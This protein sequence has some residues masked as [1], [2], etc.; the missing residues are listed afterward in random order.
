MKKNILITGASSGI[1]KMIAEHLTKKGYHVVGT[2]RNLDTSSPFDMIQLDVNDDTS[3]DNAIKTFITQY[4][5]IDVVINNAGFGICGSIEDTSMDEVRD[6]FE[7]NFFGVV[8][9]IKAVLPHMREQKEGMI[10]NISSIGGLIGLP[11]QGF[12][13]SSKFALEGLMEALRLEVKAFNI[14]AFNINPG[15]FKTGF[16]SNR[17]KTRKI[18]E[19]YKKAFETTLTIYEKDEQNAPEP[20]EIAILIEKLIKKGGNFQVRY[21][22]GQLSQKMGVTI[23]N[24]FGSKIFEKIMASTYKI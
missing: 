23:K 15:D 21:L 22:V 9:M 16:T 2:S 12:Y 6:Q 1:G 11:F 5:K 14:K 13:S 8:R 24:L 4:G 7:T 17:R 10:I 20:Q 3:V 19:V 18:S